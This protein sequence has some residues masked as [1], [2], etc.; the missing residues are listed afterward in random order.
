MKRL[1]YVLNIF[2]TAAVPNLL[3]DLASIIREKYAIRIL[4]LQ[5]VNPSDRLVLR[6]REAGIKLDSLDVRRYDLLR[7]AV[8]LKRYLRE[9]KP[10]LIHSHLG[11]ADIMSACC[12]ERRTKLV[13]TFHSVRSSYHPLTRL[14]YILT[15]RRVDV[16]TAVS[17]TVDKTWYADWRL[18]SRHRTIYNTVDP[19]RMEGAEERNIVRARYGITED[20][21]LLLNVGRLTK[22]K[23]QVHLIEAMARLVRKQRGI[24]LLI[25]GAGSLKIYSAA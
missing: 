8:R 22:Q 5:S 21:I 14:G 23:G 20:E 16:R 15:D 17:K 6:C 18:A 2:R 13:T 24:R 7:T 9:I 4:S 11:R 3:L 1:L 12:K 19:T 25:C 10:D